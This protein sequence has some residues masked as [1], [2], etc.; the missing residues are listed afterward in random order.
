MML[1]KLE[2]EY[3]RLYPTE[4]EKPQQCIAER[5]RKRVS[6]LVIFHWKKKIKFQTYR[7]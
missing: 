6:D 1:T 3:E 4:K 7:G 5:E 2:Q